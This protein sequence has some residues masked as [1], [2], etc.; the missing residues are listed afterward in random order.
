M[1]HGALPTGIDLITLSV[2]TS[3]TETSLLLP[4]VVNSNFSSGVKAS[5]QTLW[6]TSRYCST[7]SFLASITAT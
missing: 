6:P 7:S 4:L 1:P 3:I 5:C 2:G